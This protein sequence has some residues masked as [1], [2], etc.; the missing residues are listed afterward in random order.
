MLKE[1]GVLAGECIEIDTWLRYLGNARGAKDSQSLLMKFFAEVCYSVA[2]DPYA[3]TDQVLEF[4]AEASAMQASEKSTLPP[5][6]WLPQRRV[7]HR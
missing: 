2:A 3:C 4:V 6:T 5:V 7:L 1:S